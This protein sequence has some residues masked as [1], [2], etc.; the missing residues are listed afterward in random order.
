MSARKSSSGMLTRGASMRGSGLSVDGPSISPSK[1]SSIREFDVGGFHVSGRSVDEESLMRQML[2]QLDGVEFETVLTTLT[3]FLRI[4]LRVEKEQPEYSRITT[5]NHRNTVVFQNQEFTRFENEYAIMDNFTIECSDELK[6][7]IK[8]LPSS[9]GLCSIDREFQHPMS[10][11]VLKIRCV[12]QT[13]PF[14]VLFIAQTEVMDSSR[15][16]ERKHQR[17]QSEA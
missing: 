14:V 2:P 4:G 16:P 6:R 13:D 15:P 1:K 7:E 12:A 3:S 11:E 5:G 9:E 10:N 17:A 8:R